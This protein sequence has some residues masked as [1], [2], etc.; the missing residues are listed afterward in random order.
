[1]QAAAATSGRAV[2]VSG[3][4]VAI[5]MAGMFLAGAATF[6]SF[7][8]GTITVVAI[9]VVGSLT[10]LPAMLSRLGDRVN[11]GKIPFLPSPEE[12]AARESRVWSAILDPGS[13]PA[14]GRGGGVDGGAARARDPGAEP[15]LAVPGIETLPQDLE[16]IQTYDRIQAAFPGNQ[17]PA[18]S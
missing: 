11:K 6:T 17:I 2:L 7:A 18:V 9:A 4:T 1:M 16:V 8:V 10:V 15:K 13:A 14:G 5:A 12:R 3:V